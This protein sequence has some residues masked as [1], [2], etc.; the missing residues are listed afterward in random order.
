MAQDPRKD[1]NT[2]FDYLRAE[3]EL[4][5]AVEIV[6]ALKKAVD[7]NATKAELVK[8]IDEA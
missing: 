8:I 4:A 2:R 1:I 3:K 7:A 5:K 6:A